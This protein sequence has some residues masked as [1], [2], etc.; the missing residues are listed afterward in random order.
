VKQYKK[1]VDGLKAEVTK[2]KS[3]RPPAA[4]EEV[5]SVSVPEFD[6]TKEGSTACDAMIFPSCALSIYLS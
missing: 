4:K 1:Q 5:S 3:Q 6:C 2:Y